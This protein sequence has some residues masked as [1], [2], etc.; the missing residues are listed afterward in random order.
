MSWGTLGAVL[1]LEGASSRSWTLRFERRLAPRENADT[2]NQASSVWLVRDDTTTR[3]YIA[4]RQ[5]LASISEVDALVDEA[6]AW[7]AACLAD[8]AAHIVELIDVFVSRTA[9]LS[10]IFLAEFCSRGLLPKQN[11]SEPVLLTLAADLCAAAIAMPSPHAHI[12]YDSVLVDA[13][14]RVRLAGF[15]AHRSAILRDNP[16]LT[17]NDDA[18]DIGMLLYELMFGHTPPDDLTIPQQSPYS[19]R[20]ISLIEKAFSHPHPAGLRESA[21]A[22]GAE[23]LAPVVDVDRPDDTAPTAPTHVARA[24]ERNVD[25]LIDGVDIAPSFAALLSDLQADATTVASTMFKTL[26]KKPMSKD[27][28]CAVRA[29]TMIHNLSLDGPE[30][31]LDATRKNDKFMDWIESSWTK[32]VV[33]G[34]GAKGEDVHQS[35]YCFAGGE[36]AFYSAFLRRKAKF[37][38]L[39]A[40]GFSGRWDRLDVRNADGRSVLETRRRKV[41]SGMADLI[42]MASELGCLFASATDEEAP[43]KHAGLGAMVSECCLAYNAGLELAHEVQTVQAAEKLVTGIQRLYAA[44]RALVF[45]VERVPSAGGAEWVEQFAAEGPPDI[46]ADV[47]LKERMSQD[48]D[49]SSEFPKEGWENNGDAG[50]QKKDGKKKKKKKKKDGQG[51]IGVTAQAADGALVIHGADQAAT[52]FGDLLR[53]GDGTGAATTQIQEAPRPSPDMSNAKALASAFGVSED[54]VTSQYEAPP[55]NVAGYGDEEGGDDGGYETYQ[56][57]QG[58]L[59]SQQQTRGDRGPSTAAWAAQS[60]YGSRALVISENA[61][62]KSHPVFCQCAIC[63]QEEAQAAALELEAK[64][65]LDAEIHSGNNGNYEAYMPRENDYDDDQQQHQPPAAEEHRG[66]HNDDADSLDDA[67]DA[68]YRQQPREQPQRPQERSSYYQDDYDSYESVEYNVEPTAPANKY[69]ESSGTNGTPQENYG[70]PV[71]AYGESQATYGEPPAAYGGYVPEPAPVPASIPFSVDSKRKLNMKKLR[72]GDKIA[73]SDETHVLK[74]EYNRETVAV[75]KLTKKGMQSE[76]AVLNFVNEVEVMCSLSHPNVLSCVAA[77]IDKPNFVLVTEYS[78]RG[79]LFEV[80]YKNRIRLTWALIK[81]IALQVATGMAHMHERGFLHRDLK[82]LNVF[83]DSSYNVKIGDFGLSRR[84]S[85]EDGHGLSGTYQYMA[86]EVLRG[87]SH[88][89]KSDVFSYGHFMCELVSGAP[90]F[91]GMDISQVRDMVVEGG[92]PPIPMHC[93]RAYI[94]IIQKCWAAVPSTRPSFAEIG[95]LINS[96]K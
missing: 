15:G 53:I 68:T 77:S 51:T 40:G 56:A 19:Q 12:A 66:R 65:G 96:I 7:R 95:T 21:I 41:V 61:N 17:P 3:L 60:G 76:V 35:V 22:A 25:R 14:G 78:K 62:K 88:T 49:D 74:T 71:G 81:K 73:E 90:P 55:P 59:Q 5:S 42:E 72:P 87:E 37:H 80:L 28:L 82:T 9:P 23:P 86:P 70:V 52:M 36:L 31:V 79:S 11:L 44:S 16:G 94:T 2:Q 18:F 93:Q 47:A 85:S 50:V 45:A 57:H 24:V 1:T 91:P 6:A 30:P 27:P 54:A 84:M 8:D 32:E 67:P 75:K 33:E 34:K 83:A 43:A 4:K 26:F 38:M 46:V 29:L 13:S 20:L 64:G 92:R 69:S 39:A 10:V 63:Q 89:D 58:G 48:P